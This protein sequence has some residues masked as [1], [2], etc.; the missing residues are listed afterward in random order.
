MAIKRITISVPER[1]AARIKKAAGSA[2]VSAWVTDAIED[3][4]EDAEL[5]RAWAAFVRDVKPTREEARRAHAMYERLLKPPRR[6]GA[7]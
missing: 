4:L 7:A 1:V 5:E 2:P 6:R 3:R